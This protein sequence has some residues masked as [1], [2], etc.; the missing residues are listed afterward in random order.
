MKIQTQLPPDPRLSDPC[1]STSIPKKMN[2]I[3]GYLGGVLHRSQSDVC[4]GGGRMECSDSTQS[5]LGLSFITSSFLIVVL[6]N[7]ADIQHLFF[8]FNPNLKLGQSE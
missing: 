8:Y 3:Q 1:I 7:M 4:Y 2:A 5:T 6:P